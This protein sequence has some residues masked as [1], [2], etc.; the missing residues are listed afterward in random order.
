MEEENPNL[1]KSF[2]QQP[3]SPG[4]KVN[5][6]AQLTRHNLLLLDS[7]ESQ[8]KHNSS[9][10]TADFFQN[11]RNE[12]DQ[13]KNQN[14]DL[15]VEELSFEHDLINNNGITI[16]NEVSENNNNFPRIEIP[17]IQNTENESQLPSVLPTFHATNELIEIS[18]DPR[19][20]FQTRVDSLIEIISQNINNQKLIY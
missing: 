18:E 17:I 13:Y 6:S 16:N 3:T 8:K 14:K 4:K 1:E 10:D 19:I 12:L 2:G 7:N 5:K 11:L 15:Q 9:G 20:I